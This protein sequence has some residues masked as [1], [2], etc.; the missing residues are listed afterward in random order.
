VPTDDFLDFE[1]MR[2]VDHLEAEIAEYRPGVEV[3]RSLFGRVDRK[4]LVIIAI[5]VVVGFGARVYRLDAAGLAEDEANKIFALRAYAHGDFTVNGEHPMLMKLMCYASVRAAGIWN[6]AAGSMTRLAVTEETALRL[7]NALFGALTVIPLFL[8]AAALFGDKVALITAAMWA[9]GLNAIWFN[10]IAK[11]D[12]LLVFFMLC[13]YCL[14][15]YA[16]RRPATDARGA[17]R[18]YALSGAAFG[19]MLASKYFPHFL[20]L[21]FV[22]YTMIG[23][24]SRDNRPVGRRGWACF[25]AALAGALVVVNPALFLPQTWRYLWRYVNE[26]LLT[27]HGYL[28]M[29]RLYINDMAQTPGGNP[30]YFYLLSVG[31]KM[32]LPLL[33]ALIAGLIEIFRHRGFYPNSRGY[34]FLRMMLI[35]WLLPMSVVGTKFLRYSLSLMP[36]L[37]LS[38]AVGAVVV[39]RWLTRVI[40]KAGIDWR[41]ARRSAWALVGAVF[42][43]LPAV[44]AARALAT[45][46]PG[47]FVNELAG[48][49][50]GYFFPHDEF[51]DLGARESIKYIA[52]TAPTGARMASEIPGVVEYYLDRFRRPDV[53]SEILSQPKFSL[54]AGRPDYVLLQRGRVYVENLASTEEIEANWQVVQSSTYG[55]ATTARVYRAP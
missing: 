38:A 22:F 3:A 37:Y 6:A 23:Y 24:D 41:F 42:V 30:W 19:L 7:P 44:S 27:H 4:R 34:L 1:R 50:V 11:E 8:L 13:G 39:A 40:A 16:K 14:Y 17:H 46:Q 26:E 32:P 21:N 35:F 45:S 36:I 43:A 48:N 18:L 54:S 55:S 12:T 5:V 29:D 31:V 33:V 2:T 28:V 9:T 52:D 51:Y 20:G 10:R 53:R 47:L 15:G 25:F 49:R